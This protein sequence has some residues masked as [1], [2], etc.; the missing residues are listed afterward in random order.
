MRRPRRP[1]AASPPSPTAR[2]RT[3]CPTVRNVPKKKKKKVCA[4]GMGVMSAGGDVGV[5]GVFFGGVAEV[6]VVWG[7]MLWWYCD[8]VVLVVL[9]YC[10]G[11][12]VVGMGVGVTVVMD[13]WMDG[14]AA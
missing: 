12:G 3:V 5:G 10:G 11:C 4:S 2:S 8:V 1:S 9:K 14:W 6:V 7:W 13:G